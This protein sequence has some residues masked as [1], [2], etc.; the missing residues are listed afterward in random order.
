MQWN[1]Y[2]SHILEGLEKHALDDRES[3][4]CFEQKSE[5]ITSMSE[6]RNYSHGLMKGL[7]EV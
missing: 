3:L 2:C 6:L 1:I 4:K 5:M 7:E